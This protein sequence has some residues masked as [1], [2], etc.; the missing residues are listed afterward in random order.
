MPRFAFVVARPLMDL[1]QCTLKILNFP[2]VIDFLPL[3]Q[4]Q[5]FQHFLHFIKRMFEF[6]DDSV[7]LLDG[8]RNGGRF[9]GGFRLL[10]RSVL[11]FLAFLTLRG[12]LLA[13]RRLFLML[14]GLFHGGRGGFGCGGRS[15][16]FIRGRGRAFARLA[17]ARMAAA[18][19]SGAAAA[20]WGPGGGLRLSGGALFCFVRRHKH[21]LPRGR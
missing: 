15:G 19:A 13:L 21:R 1:A 17:A 11:P 10:L 5:R 14:L 3:G 6:V 18:T 8:V 20:S 12:A 9:V 4:F 2:L 16:G 7:H